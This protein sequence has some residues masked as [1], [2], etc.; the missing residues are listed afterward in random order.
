MLTRPSNAANVDEMLRRS[1]G[2]E[3]PLRWRRLCGSADN[4]DRVLSQTADAHCR[5]ANG[6]V[7]I[8]KRDSTITASKLCQNG[9]HALPQMPIDP[10]RL[11]RWRIVEKG[12]E[13]LT[14]TSIGQINCDIR[15]KDDKCL[16]V[17]ADSKGLHKRAQMCTIKIS[18]FRDLRLF[19]IL[20]DSYIF[21]E[22]FLIGI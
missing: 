6:F 1:R 7:D 17:N 16:A 19:W 5:T 18:D 3:Q 21:F 22:V 2:Q 12:D 9:K 10:F 20:P 15:E 8:G 11:R 4:S 13:R 14:A